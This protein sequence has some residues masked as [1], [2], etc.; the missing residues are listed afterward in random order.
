MSSL[1]V[2]SRRLE[3]AVARLE[4]MIVSGGKLPGAVP[5]GEDRVA[6]LGREVDLLGVECDSLRRALEEAE[7]RNR[8]L[9]EAAD[10]VASRLGRTIDELA[11]IVEG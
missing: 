6:Q 4:A 1:E 3:A 5:G 7:T 10:D 11:V 8:R 2:A 9:S